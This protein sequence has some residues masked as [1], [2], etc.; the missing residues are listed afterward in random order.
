MLFVLYLIYFRQ[1][2]KMNAKA[3]AG[4]PVYLAPEVPR[5]PCNP[6]NPYNPN[7]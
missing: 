2:K 1:D 7:P 6:C 3:V 4:T 5:N